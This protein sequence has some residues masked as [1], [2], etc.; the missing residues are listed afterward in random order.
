MEF[1]RLPKLNYVKKLRNIYTYRIQ[2]KEL[3]YHTISLLARCKTCN[4]CTQ[5]GA[6]G[7]LLYLLAAS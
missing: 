2:P 5:T 6:D 4:D 1:D 7:V 3:T